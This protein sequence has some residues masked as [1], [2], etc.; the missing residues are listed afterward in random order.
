[1]MDLHTQRPKLLWYPNLPLSLLG[2]LLPVQHAVGSIGYQGVMV[3]LIL[4]IILYTLIQPPAD[5]LILLLSP[6]PF[7]CCGRPP[8]LVTPIIDTPQFYQLQNTTITIHQVGCI[9]K[10]VET[11]VL[12]LPIGYHCLVRLV[13]LHTLDNILVPILVVIVGPPY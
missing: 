12:S 5:I 9:I 8:Y 4:L 13:E 7:L 2:G 6:S 11:S 3:H 1:M 10:F